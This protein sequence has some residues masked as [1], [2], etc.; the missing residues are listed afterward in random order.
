MGACLQIVHVLGASKQSKILKITLVEV[1]SQPP[2]S[3]HQDRVVEGWKMIQ[4]IT[5]HTCADMNCWYL[6]FDCVKSPSCS[7]VDNARLSD[8]ACWPCA[9]RNY[10]SSP[11]GFN[12]FNVRPLNAIISQATNADHL[13]DHVA[14]SKK[15]PVFTC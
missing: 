11:R 7:L 5:N 13:P 4:K 1:L 12:H 15:K 6:P 3:H 2:V 9:K 14:D 8:A 10:R